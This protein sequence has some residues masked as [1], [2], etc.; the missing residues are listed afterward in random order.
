MDWTKLLSRQRL[1]RRDS[2]SMH[3]RSPFQRDYDRIVFSSAF[4]RLQD[5]TQVFPLAESDYVRTRLTHS[6]EV[7]CVGRSL[8]TLVGTELLK[9]H[10]VTGITAQDVGNIV[11]AASL[12]HD[13]GN[14]PFGHSGED[15][16]RHWFE[17]RG[18]QYL[19]DLKPAEK[20]D[21]LKFEGNAQGFRVLTRLQNPHN[22]GG[23]QLTYAV[24][25]AFSKYPRQ[26]IVPGMQ[27]SK[28]VSEKKF[29]FFSVD[30][31]SFREIAEG[32]GLTAKGANAWSRH[33]L[34]FLTEAAD[35]ICYRIVDFEDGFRLGRVSFSEVEQPLTEIAFENAGRESQSRYRRVSDERAKIEMLR[36]LAINTLVHAAVEVFLKHSN[37]I[38]DGQF[39]NSLLS[40][41]P[42]RKQ[43]KV[44]E[45]LSHEKVYAT[46]PVAQIETA[47]FE[48]LGGL[49]ERIVPVL[50]RDTKKLSS[51]EQKLLQVI[52]PQFRNGPR[53][54][55]GLHNATDFVAGM[56]D[57]YAVT[58][59]RRL[60]GIELPKGS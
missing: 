6:I 26:S 32:L 5:K 21:F 60:R 30:Y 35:D 7:S 39:G 38:L 48:V 57:S 44:I 10:H 31:S 45:K 11:A 43:I 29:G 51:A 56:T 54:N 17:T 37:K 28:D 46:Q 9:T 16:I 12:A 40:R 53:N 2:G 15:A 1:G 49:L 3:A 34:A 4:R 14:P 22:R 27:G 19:S 59:Y 13:I 25:G 50:T 8:G 42:Y 58:L 24:L 33:P 55:S 18:K 36:A 23:L 52:P 47:G 20:E 41:V